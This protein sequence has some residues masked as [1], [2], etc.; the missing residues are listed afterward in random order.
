[1]K[2]LK[3]RLIDSWGNVVFDKDGLIDLLMQGSE[4]SNDLQTIDNS[5]IHKF[6]KLCREW[7]H[8][9][10]QL[11]IYQEPSVS[12]EE[13][14]TAFQSEWFIP[15]KYQDLDVLEW[16]TGRCPT[17]E[18]LKR[19]AEEWA[20]FEERGMTQVLRLLIYLVD[21]F[22]ERGIVWGVGRGSSVASYI[23]YL[24]GVHKID[25]LAFNL[26]VHEFLK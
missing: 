8:P 21:N 16:L 6:N 9:E 13:W 12:V 14:D 26:D 20:L 2:E 15:E 25:S 4:L 7:D 10:D 5:D 19:V 22:R 3:G 17:D 23:L 24:I 11:P 18:A 1:M